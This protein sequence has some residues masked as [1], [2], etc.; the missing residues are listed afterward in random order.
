MRCQ[1]ILESSDKDFET[2]IRKTFQ[3]AI[4][5]TIKTHE[6]IESLSREIEIFSKEIEDKKNQ[7]ETETE[8]FNNL[9]KI[10]HLIG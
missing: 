4:I 9:G 5:N 6:K 3:G 7:K 2:A 10:S 8:K 1:Q